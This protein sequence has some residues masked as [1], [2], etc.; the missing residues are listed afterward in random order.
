MTTRRP[1]RLAGR[2]ALVFVMALAVFAALW[3][4][5]AP[6]YG[7]A[8][9]A[10]AQPVFRWI[11]HPQVTVLRA[12]ADELWVYRSVGEDRVAPF[13]FFDR[14]AFFA[15]V[16]LLALLAATPD[17]QWGRRAAMAAGG[18][19]ALF[20]LHVLYVVVSVQLA[21]SAAGLTSGGARETAQWGVRLLWEA[22]PIVIW[23]LFTFRAWRRAFGAL[24]A[25]TPAV[26]SVPRP[27]AAAGM[28]ETN[29]WT[30]REGR[31]V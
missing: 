29:L 26:C 9:S 27:Q 22:A 8:I 4:V 13:M 10:A 5:A 12:E 28:E 7:A 21:Y 15:V 1:S 24:R 18:A 3:G 6:R 2:F 31:T 23:L 20:A 14:Y 11:E 25:P 16:L 30:R 19:A 17:L